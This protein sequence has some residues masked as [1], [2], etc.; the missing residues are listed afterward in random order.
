M[1]T[2]RTPINIGVARSDADLQR[3]LRLLYQR[4]AA[5]D[6]LIRAFEAYGQVASPRPSVSEDASGDRTSW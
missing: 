5:L 2:P 6:Q 1:A 3:E 4:R